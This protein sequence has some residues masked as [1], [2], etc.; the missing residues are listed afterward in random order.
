GM[1]VNT[2]ILRNYPTEKKPFRDFLREVKERTLQAFENRDYPFEYLVAAKGVQKETGNN[3]LFNVGF[4]LQNFEMPTGGMPV[5]QAGEITLK[6][7]DFNQRISKNDLTLIF[8]PA[9][10]RLEAVFQYNTRVFEEE[11]LLLMRDRFLVLLEDILED[12]GKTIG[13]LDYR[14]PVETEL[15]SDREI[16]FNF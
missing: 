13:Q 3:P 5:I 6:P 8:S 9:G 16:E 2:L 7:Y 11:S 15:R 12:R 14:T 10:D 1:F 4:T